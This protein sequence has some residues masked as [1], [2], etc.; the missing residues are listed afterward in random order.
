MWGLG[1]LA[2]FGVA[3]SLLTGLALEL[4]LQSMALVVTVAA[5]EPP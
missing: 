5:L 4:S 3:G 2:F 1:V